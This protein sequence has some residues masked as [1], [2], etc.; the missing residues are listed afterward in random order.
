MVSYLYR[1]HF[2]RCNPV[3]VWHSAAFDFSQCITLYIYHTAYRMEI[4]VL[5]YKQNAQI[6]RYVRKCFWY[7]RWYC[8]LCIDHKRIA[9]SRCTLIVIGNR[10]LSRLLGSRSSSIF[11]KTH[12]LLAAETG[13]P[14]SAG[15]GSR[16]NEG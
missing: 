4:Y 16:H 7:G 11:D 3:A 14:V 12:Y 5:C 9:F 15:I 10:H 13:K 6:S 8:Y 2:R 1:S